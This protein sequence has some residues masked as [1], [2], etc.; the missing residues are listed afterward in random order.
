MNFL[1]LCKRL[2][3][4]AG[5]S[6][7]GPST[8]V[9]QTGEAKRIV[10]W[11]NDAWIDLQKMRS[12]W[13][14][15]LTPFEVSFSSGDS[16]ALLSDDFASI[17]KGK[18]SSVVVT[19][20]DGSKVFPAELKPEEMRMLQRESEDMPGDPLYFSVDRSGEMTVFPSCAESIVVA[21]DY[22]KKP[23]LMSENTDTPILPE[24]YHMAIVWL[25]LMSAGA[26]DEASNTYQRG[27]AK[28]TEFLSDIS[29]TE[30]PTI[31]TGGPIA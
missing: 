3:Q 9:G 28:F 22:H 8:V 24:E 20:A 13:R 17:K 27:N 29:R 23:A 15:M 18:K 14:F 16:T 7:S 1:E 10:D 31:T 5:Y 26:Y 12:D 4:E 2:R 6:G 11:V 25:G 21:G 19:R 30:L